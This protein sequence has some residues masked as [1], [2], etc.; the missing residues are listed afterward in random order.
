MNPNLKSQPEAM[1]R[2]YC[3]LCN[4]SLEWTHGR[5]YPWELMCLRFTEDDLRLVVR[6]IQRQTRKGQPARHLTFRTFIA[7]PCA[8]EYFEEDLGQ[9][10]AES[11]APKPLPGAD[12]L[13]AT[14]RPDMPDPS[15]AKPVAKVVSA[16]GLKAFEDF[17]RLASEL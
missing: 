4:I 15:D 8:V 9:A 13:R 14:R 12:V 11:R 16:L 17:K 7:G 3:E 2:L 1:H 10:R 5:R 6:W